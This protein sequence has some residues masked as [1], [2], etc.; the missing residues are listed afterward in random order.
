MCTDSYRGGEAFSAVS[1][2]SY[3]SITMPADSDSL[4]TFL[5]QA[6]TRKGRTS[7]SDATR[8]HVTPFM[9]NKWSQRVTVR[10][11]SLFS[12]RHHL[13]RQHPTP[14]LHSN[15]PLNNVWTR[16]RWKGENLT[17]YPRYISPA[18]ELAPFAVSHSENG[19]IA[20]VPPI[21]LG[22]GRC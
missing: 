1:I 9:V 7:Q 22:Q 4:R 12:Y 5:E 13:E 15:N 3:P 21:G 18:T 2:L 14:P 19:V 16:K 6:Q 8:F 11:H 20:D 17:P 10:S